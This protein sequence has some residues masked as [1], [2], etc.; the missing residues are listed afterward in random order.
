[1]P[2]NVRFVVTKLLLVTN[3][4]FT[5][6]LF[7]APIKLNVVPSNVKLSDPFTTL[8]LTSATTTVFAFAVPNA[9]VPEPTT[10]SI[11]ITLSLSDIV[12]LEPACSL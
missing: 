6:T 10:A 1:M 11:V 7:A 2:P 9:V 3:P 5:V 12:A 8:P 4:L